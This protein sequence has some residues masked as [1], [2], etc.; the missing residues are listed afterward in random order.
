MIAPPFTIS[1]DEIDEIVSRFKTALAKTL[2][3]C[4]VRA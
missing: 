1:E 4:H 3:N 2:E